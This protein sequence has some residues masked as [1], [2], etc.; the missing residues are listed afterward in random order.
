M[1]IEPP[2]PLITQN[3]LD[4]V[5]QPSIAWDDDHLIDV[6]TQTPLYL[7]VVEHVW[8]VTENPTIAVQ[9]SKPSFDTLA[10]ARALE[11]GT[12]VGVDCVTYV[13][14]QE[15][16]DGAPWAVSVPVSQAA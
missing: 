9:V 12:Y 10:G 8:E 11:D 5:S 3:L 13:L 1:P 14:A 7:T 4:A 6:P 2:D 15:T 16:L